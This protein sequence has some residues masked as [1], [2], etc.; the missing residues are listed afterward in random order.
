MKTKKINYDTLTTT[1]NGE[2]FEHGEV[3]YTP[4]VFHDDLTN[5]DVN[6]SF[7]TSNDSVGN[8]KDELSVLLAK[9]AQ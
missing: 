1:Y 6:F 9:Y 8:F 5:V 3:V 4:N 2:V 7:A